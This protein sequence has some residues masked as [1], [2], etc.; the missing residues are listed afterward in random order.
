MEFGR[1]NRNTTVPWPDNYYMETN[2]LRREE[3]LKARLEEDDSEENQIRYQLWQS[4]YNGPGKKKAGAD[5]YMRALLSM[6]A[7]VEKKSSFL[8]KKTYQKG[9]RMLRDTFCL[10][11]LKEKPQYAYLWRD[12]F[13]HLWSIYIEACRDDRNYSSIMLGVGRMSQGSLVSK[14]KH[15]IHQ[16]SVI[17]PE[18]LG[19]SEELI[20]FRQAAREAFSYYYPGA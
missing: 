10:D 18:E 11:L 14:I 6:G 17:L 8:G 9:V 2:P 12:E 20:Q 13:V 16:K 5:Y 1:Y 15:D 19:L 3:L 7:F 4:R